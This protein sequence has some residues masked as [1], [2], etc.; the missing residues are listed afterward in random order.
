MN[1]HTQLIGCYD[2]NV[3]ALLIEMIIDEIPNNI[4]FGKFCVPDNMI[5]SSDWQVAYMEQFLTLDGTGKLCEVYDI[6]PEQSKPSR[7]AFFLFKTENH[8]LSTPYGDFSIINHQ[9]T[10]ERIR[11]LIEFHDFD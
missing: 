9:E 11:G 10:P 2:F 6:P 5:D 7:I 3:D 4:D 1:N 8:E